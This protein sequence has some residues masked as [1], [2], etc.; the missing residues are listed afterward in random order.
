MD[1]LE[2]LEFFNEHFTDGDAGA[3]RLVF[4][5]SSNPLVTDGDVIALGPQTGFVI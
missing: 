3:L 4:Q 5:S 1:F 2:A